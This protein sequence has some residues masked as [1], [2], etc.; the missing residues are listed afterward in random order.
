[1]VIFL[2]PNIYP[3]KAIGG[4]PQGQPILVI[5]VS[6]DFSG[7][8]YVKTYFDESLMVSMETSWAFL[9]VTSKL[10][11]YSLYLATFHEIAKS[12]KLNNRP[13]A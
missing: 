12:P 10:S 6:Y 2:E 7:Y 3:G 9:K 5:W 8:F 1:M 11:K 4:I 13:Y